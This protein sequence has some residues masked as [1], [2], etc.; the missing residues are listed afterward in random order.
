MKHSMCQLFTGAAKTW[1]IK[2]LPRVDEVKCWSCL[3]TRWGVSRHNALFLGNI[4]RRLTSTC[5]REEAAWK[6]TGT[7]CT[8]MAVVSNHGC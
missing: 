2:T 3:A 5:A 8:W 4:F 1:L 7:T 6:M